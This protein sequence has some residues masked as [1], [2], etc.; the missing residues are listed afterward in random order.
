[1]TKPLGMSK[2]MHLLGAAA[3]AALAGAAQAQAPK[4]V[5]LFTGPTP[6]YDSIWMADAR[7]FF[8]EEGL[9]VT[10][11]L[12]PSGTTALQTFKTGQGD[13]VVNGD[14]P[15]VAYWEQ[16]NKD[17]RLVTVIERDAITYRATALK[18]ITKP[19]DLKGK[20]IATR[21]GST[22]SW[23]IS[24]YLKKN[25]MT[26]A[27]VTIKNLD[28]QVLPTAL[29]Q[30]EIAAFFIWQPFGARALEICPDRAHYLTTAEGYINGYAVM[31]ARPAWLATP[32][33]RDITTR[34]LRA[35]VKGRAVAEK[36]FDA[37]AKYANEKYSLSRDATKIQW[38]VNN[39]A[40][41]FD[42]TFYADHCSL[43]GWMRDNKL[44]SGNFDVSQY[45]WTEG[46]AA[47]LPGSVKAPPKP[48]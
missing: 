29:C 3:I 10:F 7:G 40:L 21:V 20:I 15:G 18:E 23:F 4:K 27:D 11:R 48:C 38:D 46:I 44:M 31:G 34:F 14:L 24:T 25:G 47:A 36:D 8:K 39:R 22:G 17:Y 6:L 32:E 5:T 2:W 13:L 19:Q 1:M 43:A 42:E 33:G 28:T 12:F 37:V 26:D 16:N 9:D 41:G 30:R 45:I 35:M